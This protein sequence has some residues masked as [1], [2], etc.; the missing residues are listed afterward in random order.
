MGIPPYTRIIFM[1]TDDRSSHEYGISR[2]VVVLLILTAFVFIMFLAMLMHSFASKHNERLVIE[3]LESQLAVTRSE[4]LVVHE[5]EA[6]LEDMRQA[7]EQLLLLLGVEGMDPAMS[8]SLMGVWS[9]GEAGS[10]SEAMRRAASV[11]ASPK[12]NRWPAR[13]FVTKEFIVGSVAN[14]VVPHQGVDIAGPAEGPVLAAA[15]GTV[16]REGFDEYL[17]N[18]AEIQHGM[19]YLTVYGH[20]QRIVVSRGDH[21][22]A[23]QVIG[24]VGRTGQASANHLHFEIW[25]QGEAVDPR[26]FVVGE[27]EQN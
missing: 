21:I 13:G 1:P 10:S 26:K 17:G 14:G 15:R 8:D 7:Q 22:T 24:Y 9:S 5:L 6:N 27:P 11:V 25:E 20:C 2:P 23:G 16:V 4:V 12:P 18:F 3:E 19:G